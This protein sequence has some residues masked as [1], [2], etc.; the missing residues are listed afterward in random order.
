MPFHPSLRFVPAKFWIPQDLDLADIYVYIYIYNTIYI[1]T[2]IDIL[3]TL[4]AVGAECIGFS[5]VAP[6]KGTLRSQD[7]TIDGGN[8]AAL[9]RI[10][11]TT[12]DR[13]SSSCSRLLQIGPGLPLSVWGHRTELW[14]NKS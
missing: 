2:Y 5:T 3:A 11:G 12:I 13:H 8:P 14:Y 9:G 6:S 1:Y 10:R 4:D 7:E